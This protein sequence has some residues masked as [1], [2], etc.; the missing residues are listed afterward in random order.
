MSAAYRR[1]MASLPYTQLSRRESQVMEAVYRRGEATVAQVMEELPDPPGYNSVRSTLGILAKKGH[2]THRKDGRRFVYVP[3]I[4]RRVAQ[5]SVL[6]GLLD[7]FFERSTVG[8]VSTLIDIA[9]PDLSEE[10]LNEISDLIAKT[11]SRDKA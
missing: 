1:I 11:R 10:E 5:R 6:K 7:T 8:A 2:L 9:A 4:P 3:K